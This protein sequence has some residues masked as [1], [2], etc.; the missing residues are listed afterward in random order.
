MPLVRRTRATLRRAELGFLGVTVRTCTQ[1]PRFWG[2]PW[3][4]TRRPFNGLS[5][6]RKAGALVFL[7]TPLRPRRTNWF[8]VGKS[9]PCA[10]TPTALFE[11]SPEMP[12]HLVLVRPLA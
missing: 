7:L 11:L 3:P 2:E 10:T 1:T 4:K 5:R 6:K 12:E 9:P 8:M